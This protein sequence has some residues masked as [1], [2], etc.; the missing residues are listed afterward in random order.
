MGEEKVATGELSED[1]LVMRAM[2]I[3]SRKVERLAQERDQLAQDNQLLTTHMEI[4]VHAIT[5][6]LA[7][8]AIDHAV[9]NL[10][11]TTVMD[12]ARKLNG[13]DLQKIQKPLGTMNY[14]YRRGGSWAVYAKRVQNKSGNIDKAA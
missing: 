2:S 10:R 8:A 14:L 1:E 4:Q 9:G 11:S 6:M 5:A 7:A 13:V 12:F 3:M